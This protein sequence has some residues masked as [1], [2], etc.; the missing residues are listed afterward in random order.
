MRFFFHVK[1]DGRT[2]HDVEGQDL[3]GPE[4]AFSEAVYSARELVAR[5]LLASQAVDWAGA[6]EIFYG[7]QPAGSVG[8][9]EAV[10]IPASKR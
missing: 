2:A 3:P 5:R 6:I 7:D 10:G 9:M 8:F 4:A 1:T